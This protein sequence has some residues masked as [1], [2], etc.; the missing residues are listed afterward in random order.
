MG[1]Q[2]TERA[3]PGASCP[4]GALPSSGGQSG[5]RRNVLAR[6][7]QV[8]EGQLCNHESCNHMSRRRAGLRRAGSRQ[9]WVWG[10][11]SRGPQ[12]PGCTPGS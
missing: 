5:V 11:A 4:R 10:V 8:S 2:R 1:G 6:G 12:I 9:E 3:S 7:D